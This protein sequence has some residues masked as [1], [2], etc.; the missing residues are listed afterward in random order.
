VRRTPSARAETYVSL[1]QKPRRR[2]RDNVSLGVFQINGVR[3]REL[4]AKP[5]ISMVGLTNCSSGGVN[6]ISISAPA[7]GALHDRRTRRRRL[8]RRGMF[9]ARPVTVVVISCGG[10]VAGDC[11]TR[12]GGEPKQSTS[13]S[14]QDQRRQRHLVHPPFKRARNHFS[15]VKRPF[16][17]RS[18]SSESCFAQ[19]FGHEAPT[20]CQTT[21]R[22]LAH[23]QEESSVPGSCRLKHCRVHREAIVALA[24]S[25]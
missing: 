17:R 21:W 9:R 11:Q 4:W 8:D 25:D 20:R 7:L 3:R 6:A 14:A 23:D 12:H 24:Q 15:R 13:K 10:R 19:V 22:S 5:T 18:N 2:Q 16:L 1:C